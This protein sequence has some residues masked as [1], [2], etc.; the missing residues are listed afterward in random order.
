MIAYLLLH[1]LAFIYRTMV[2]HNH[3]LPRTKWVDRLDYNIFMDQTLKDAVSTQVPLEVYLRSS[4]YGN[5]R[6]SM[7]R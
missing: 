4:G 2:V 5:R 3:G 6:L 7:A 1:D